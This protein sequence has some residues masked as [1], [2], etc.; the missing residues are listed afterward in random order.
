MYYDGANLNAIL[1]VARPGDMGFDVTH[2]NLH[3]TF[4]TPHGGGG[5]G[6]GPVGVKAQLIPYLPTVASQGQ[7]GKLQM[8]AFHGNFSVLV[9]ALCYLKTLG[10]DSLRDVAEH[11][12]LNANYLMKRLKDVGYTPAKDVPCMHEF[13]LTLEHI[14]ET[15]GVSALDVAKA[16]IDH[17]MHPPTM[18]FPMIVHEALMFEPTETET[19]ETLDHAAAAMADILSE[20]AQNP[21]AMHSAPHNAVI[22]R[23]DDVKAARNP[24]LHWPMNP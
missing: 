20:L 6:S 8:K 22:G 12:V 7:Q 10:C 24:I 3:K 9:R 1:G 5:P 17:G 4:S 13:V 18:Y 23:P 19:R 21:E 15:Y 11:A 16:L 2:F 14:K